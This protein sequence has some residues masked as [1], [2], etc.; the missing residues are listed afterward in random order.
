[1]ESYIKAEKILDK[2]I[3]EGNVTRKHIKNGYEYYDKNWNQ[4]ATIFS[5]GDEAFLSIQSDSF[6]E[7]MEK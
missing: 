1:M 4:L 3:I 7:M 2:M 5:I 6:L